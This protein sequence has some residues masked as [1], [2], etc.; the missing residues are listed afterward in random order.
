MINEVDL[1]SI[2][3]C[4]KIRSTV[5]NLREFWIRRHPVLPFYTLG[6]ASPYDVPK[7][8]LGYYKDSEKHNSI[9]HS[10]FQ[11]LYEKLLVVIGDF[12]K[13]P[14]TFAPNLA[15]PGFHIFLSNPA[16]EQPLGTI[17]C[18][19]SYMFHWKPSPEVDFDHPISF[20][21]AI[22]LPR[23]GGG[24]N[25]WDLE[26]KEVIDLDHVGIERI[27]SNKKRTYYPYQ[28]GKLLLHSGHTVHQIA[29]I[30]NIQLEDDR[31][32]LQGHGILYKNTWQLHW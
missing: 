30:K 23:S 18:D 13:K 4:Q 8:K 12:L 31:I 11:W 27:A 17:H 24:M 5:Y 22:S 28:I 3:E 21:Q 25:I 15:L 10:N 14:A 7:D 9:L 16:F 29:P 20:T 2:E 26:Y 32:T 19:K 1:L 6:L